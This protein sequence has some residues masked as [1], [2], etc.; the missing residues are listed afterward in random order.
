MIWGGDPDPARAA[1]MLSGLAEGGHAGAQRSLA[2]LYMNGNGV[3]TEAGDLVTYNRAAAIAWFER[4]VEL[5][6]EETAARLEALQSD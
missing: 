5:G 6:H 3:E 4:A 2:F 1:E